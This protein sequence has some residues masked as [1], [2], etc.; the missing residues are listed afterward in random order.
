MSTSRFYTAGPCWTL[1]CDCH[2]YHGLDAAQAPRP[3]L[4]EDCTC[5]VAEDHANQ[6][7]SVRKIIATPLV[8]GL[9]FWRDAGDRFLGV[10]ALGSGKGRLGIRVSD[11]EPFEDVWEFPSVARAILAAEIWD[12]A[13]TPEPEGWHRHPRSGRYRTDGDPG[14]EYR[15]GETP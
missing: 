13:R 9:V 15:K 1:G 10:M 12:P 6:Q 14:R 8:G 2:V 3:P 4:H 11:T 5:Y 7:G